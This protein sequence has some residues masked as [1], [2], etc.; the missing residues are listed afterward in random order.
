MEQIVLNT[1]RSEETFLINTRERNEKLRKPLSE[2]KTFQYERAK[3][4][5]ML[6]LAKKLDIDVSEFNWIYNT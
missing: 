2:N 4:I 6:D 1:L 3:F 5:G